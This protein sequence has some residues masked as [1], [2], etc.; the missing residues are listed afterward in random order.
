MHFI[1]PVQLYHEKSGL[2]HHK[3]TWVKSS[4]KFESLRSRLVAIQRQFADKSKTW[5]VA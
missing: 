4:I 2:W 1:Q 3:I 5:R